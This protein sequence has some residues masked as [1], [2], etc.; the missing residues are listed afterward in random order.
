MVINILSES[1]LQKL[2]G[3]SKVPWA[4]AVVWYGRSSPQE[5][6]L[7]PANSWQAVDTIW[8]RSMDCALKIKAS[9]Y[10][11]SLWYTVPK[12][13]DTW[14]PRDAK[15]KE[16]NPGANFPQ[17]SQ[18]Q[19]IHQKLEEEDGCGRE[20]FL[21]PGLSPGSWIPSWDNVSSKGTK[22]K[23]KGKEEKGEN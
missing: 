12:A 2:D 4:Q 22:V 14:S 19:E 7:S 3:A 8:P 13:R 16:I 23:K 1:Q 21:L 11:S 18:S 6:L 5:D 17:V 10:A 15:Y 20:L 9:V